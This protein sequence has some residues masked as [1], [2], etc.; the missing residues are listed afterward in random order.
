MP[1]D[2]INKGDWR[3]ECNVIA[4]VGPCYEITPEEVE[5]TIKNAMEVLL[6][7]KVPSTQQTEASAHTLVHCIGVMPNNG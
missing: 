1:V 4:F 2:I 3:I 6:V 5:T 7:G